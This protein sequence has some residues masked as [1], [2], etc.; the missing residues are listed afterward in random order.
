MSINYNVTGERRKELVGVISKIVGYPSVYM[1][2]PTFAFQIG[3]AIVSKNGE[4]SFSDEITE[5]TADSLVVALKEHGYEAEISEIADSDDDKNKL[6]IEIS[7]E[8]FT[9]EA[10]ANIK[11]LIAS[12]KTLIQKAIGIHDLPFD[13]NYPAVEVTEAKLRFPWFTLTDVDGEAEAYS[14]FICALCELAKSQ[15]RVSATEKPIENDKFAMRLFLVRLGLKG[16]ENKIVRQVMLKNLSG[17]SS[18]KNGQP[19]KKADEHASDGVNI[20]E[21]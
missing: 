13:E 17:N 15:K 6:A 5:N 20:D 3:Y 8:G 19:P 9:D 10:V 4:L 7:R 14:R 21:V 18:W 12:K 2:A 16:P 11:N 1:G